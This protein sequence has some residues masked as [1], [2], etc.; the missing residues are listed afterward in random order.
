MRAD[1]SLLQFALL[2]SVV[3]LTFAVVLWL[4]MR[5]RRR[6]TPGEG[7]AQGPWSFVR[8]EWSPGR[9]WTT[10]VSPVPDVAMRLQR[11]AA[12]VFLQQFGLGYLPGRL[13]SYLRAYDVTSA[14]DRY[15]ACFRIS[16][17]SLRDPG[18][19]AHAWHRMLFD[20]VISTLAQ[21]E[22]AA[23]DTGL[24]IEPVEEALRSGTAAE[25]AALLERID[26]VGPLLRDLERGVRW[27][28]HRRVAEKV[29]YTLRS[30]SSAAPHQMN[31]AARHVRRI[32]EERE[33]V[34]SLVVSLRRGVR[35][36]ASSPTLTGYA[37]LVQSEMRDTLQRV[38]R[39]GANGITVPKAI[40]TLT[41]LAELLEN[42]LG[43]IASDDPE[44]APDI[45]L[46]LEVLG[47]DRTAD[48]QAVRRAHRV[49]A[50]V[51]HPD[52]G[53]STERMQDLNVAKDTLLRFLDEHGTLGQSNSSRVA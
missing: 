42:V 5:R 9:R 41:A 7:V 23:R 26:R 29:R 53:G 4:R 17:D 21:A 44:R 16:F 52:R 50:K 35:E 6:G 18:D 37:C 34:S 2:A 8:P 47:L 40:E 13:V 30:W 46:H 1:T 24:L 51:L 28:E 19:P 14:L 25:V 33:Q 48:A 39:D 36:L 43:S 49:L 10:R 31:A 38:R 3:A 12:S 11:L 22:Q 27:P 20:A 45:D 32:R 15:C